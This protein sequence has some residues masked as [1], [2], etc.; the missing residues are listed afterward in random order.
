MLKLPFERL[1]TSRANGIRNSPTCPDHLPN[2]FR[3]PDGCADGYAGIGATC[4]APWRQTAEDVIG[5]DETRRFTHLS[6]GPLFCFLK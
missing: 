1:L 3:T 5:R 6:G 4:P 2:S